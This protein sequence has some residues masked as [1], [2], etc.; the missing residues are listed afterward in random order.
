MCWCFEATVYFG[1]AG[2][3]FAVVTNRR[4]RAREVNRKRNAGDRFAGR[5][6]AGKYDQGGKYDGGNIQCH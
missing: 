5:K 2:K 4:E 6:H 3:G 1:A